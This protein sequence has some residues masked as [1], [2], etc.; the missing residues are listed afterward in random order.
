MFSNRGVTLELVLPVVGFVV[1]LQSR[2][3]WLA[4]ATAAPGLVA[5]FRALHRRC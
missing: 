2:F 4:I 5:L 1:S 3:R